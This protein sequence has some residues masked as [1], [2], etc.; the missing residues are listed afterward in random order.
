MLNQNL[1]DTCA[2]TKTSSDNDHQE[3]IDKEKHYEQSIFDRQFD[4]GSG[5]GIHKQRHQI[6]QIYTCCVSF[7]LKGRQK[8]NRFSPR[9]S[10]ESP[11]GQLRSLPQKGSKAAIS[12]S[13][14]TRSYDTQ[15]GSRRYVTEIAADEVQF[16]STKSDEN[17]ADDVDFDDLKPIDED[18][19][20]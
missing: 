14:Q 15:D 20:F 19:P 7:L 17:G 9:R 1:T 3:V 8:R 10:M 2:T 6:L 5:T 18:L 11:S 4:K 12:G 13:I 16:L